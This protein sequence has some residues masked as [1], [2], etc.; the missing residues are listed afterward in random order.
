MSSYV[1]QADL[2]KW[3]E[4]NRPSRCPILGHPGFDPVVDHD[5]I[6]GCIRGVVSREGNSLLGKVENFFRS[7]CTASTQTLPFVLRNMADYLELQQGPLHPRGVRQIVRR[8][9]RK[10]KATQVKV[11]RS[12]GVPANL[13][14]KAKNAKARGKIYREVVIKC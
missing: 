9:E 5:H 8:F 11:L 6:T 14:D 4:D 1:K 10:S 13:I 12:L 2:A 7:R 3:R